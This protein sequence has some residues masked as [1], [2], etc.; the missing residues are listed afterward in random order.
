MPR[1]Y[2][3]RAVLAVW[4]LSGT[5]LG[6]TTNEG[7]SPFAKAYVRL[8]M[9]K[10]FPEAAAQATL[11]PGNYQPNFSFLHL[12]DGKWLMGLGGG[13]R[14]MDRQ[15]LPDAPAPSTTLAIFSFNHESSRLIPLSHPYYGL[16]GVKLSYLLP[17]RSGKLPPLRDPVYPAEIAAALSLQFVRVFDKGVLVNFRIDRWRGVNSSRLSGMEAAVG[18]GVPTD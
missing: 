5:S 13:L 8:E 10:N 7:V 14:T 3:Y 9:T 4:F 12:V 17:T 18:I 11:L 1:L 2:F 16:I 6:A 15:D